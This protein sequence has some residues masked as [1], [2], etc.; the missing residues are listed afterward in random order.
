MDAKLRGKFK[1]H[2]LARAER[3][4]TNT[5]WINGGRTSVLFR[6]QGHCDWLGWIPIDLARGMEKKHGRP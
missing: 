2:A 6:C 3:A 1:E 5:P 4:P